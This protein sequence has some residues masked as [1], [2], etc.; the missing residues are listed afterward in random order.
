VTGA[1]EPPMT[2]P[3]R[4]AA[5]PQASV[6][7]ATYNWSAAL[8]C[9]IRSVL[10]QTLRDFEILVIGDACTDDSEA[11][12]AAFADPR[13]AWINL[14]ANSGSQQGPNNH[15]LRVA[16]GEWIAYLGHDD[17]WAPRHLAST[18]DAAQAA[19][20]EAAAGGMIMYGP[21]GSDAMATAG[22]FVDRRC[23]DDDF[24]PPSALVH[25]R[26]LADRIGPWRDPRVL[27]LPTDCEYF[28]RVRAASAIAPSNELTVF[29]CNAAA[30]R[31]A[32]QSK[33]VDEQR[34]LLAGLERGDR[35]IGEELVKVVTSLLAGRT[36]RI[37]MPDS[38]SVHAGEIF[39]AN[40]VAKGVEP[41]FRAAE[42]RSLDAIET[43]HLDRE[44]AG[45]EWHAIEQHP[46][47][48][49]FRWTGPAHRSTIE[50]PVRLDRPLAMRIHVARVIAGQS[51]DDVCVDAQGAAVTIVVEREEN[52]CWIL[53]GLI[54]PARHASRVPYVQITL[55]GITAAR[56]ADLGINQDMRRLG[57]AVS[58]VELG[59]A[60]R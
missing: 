48:G 39:R 12:V 14:N 43:F 26:T 13:I 27:Q 46:H 58:H 51:I 49:S 38:A 57:I 44:A 23:S 2:Y 56:P 24:V 4:A 45:Y 35:F 16:R 40:R 17:I 20:A 50:L 21:P 18:I 55:G 37:R 3:A 25:R 32:Y 8:A 9:A 28:E 33:S 10:R 11:V 59:P 54:D 34:A 29:K 15:G 36:T 22:L 30:R 42:L 60:V 1:V 41:R 52:D 6:I 7:I 5:S 53:S 47:L 31:N 19:G